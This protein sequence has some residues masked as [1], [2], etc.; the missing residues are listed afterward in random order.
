MMLEQWTARAEESLRNGWYWKYELVSVK[1]DS[2][3]PSAGGSKAT[4]ECT[5]QET[6]QLYDGGQPDLNDSYKAK[7][8]ARYVMEWFPEDVCWKIT[9]GVVLPNK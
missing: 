6:A 2:V 4:V 5:L 3:T 7:Y 8:Q 9:S 1:V